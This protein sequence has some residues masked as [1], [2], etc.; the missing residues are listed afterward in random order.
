MLKL[1]LWQAGGFVIYYKRLERGTFELPALPD[2]AAALEL[3]L[4]ELMMLIEGIELGSVKRRRRF[5]R[6]HV[7]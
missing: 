6:P 7:L 5:I 3:G 1:L 2:T 4:S